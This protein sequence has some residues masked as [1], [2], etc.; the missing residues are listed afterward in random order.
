MRWFVA[1]IFGC[2]LVHAPRALDE[3]LEEN[4]QKDVICGGDFMLIAKGR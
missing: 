4:Y 2:L 1:L 3:P